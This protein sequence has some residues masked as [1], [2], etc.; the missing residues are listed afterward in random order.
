MG[1][2]TG[3]II[4][5]ALVVV[6][7]FSASRMGQLGNALGKFVYSF[8]RASRGHDLVDATPPKASRELPP[9]KR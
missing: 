7:I 1:L 4:I 9:D 2:G 8:K 5:I 3:E 6:I